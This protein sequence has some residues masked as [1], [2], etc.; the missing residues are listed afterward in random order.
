MARMRGVTEKPE[1]LRYVEEFVSAA[2][3]ADLLRRLADI[4]YAEVRMRG[5]VARRRVRHYG[6]SYSYDP[7]EVSPGDPLPSWLDATRCR[8][9]A[10]VGVPPDRLVECLLTW[11]PPGATI[12]WHRDA[13]MFGDVVGVSVGSA[14]VLRFQR[15]RG[16]DRHVFE[17][18]LQERS[19]YVLTGPSRTSWQHS[20]PA[21]PV[22][23]FSITFRTLRWSTRGRAAG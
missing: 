10:L 11:Y 12:G 13:P 18:P 21:V 7:P 23:R 17:Q 4:D 2:E 14:C 3:H 6:V 16:E 19:A 1:G 9:A 15:G 20:I 22:D 8:C 5:Q